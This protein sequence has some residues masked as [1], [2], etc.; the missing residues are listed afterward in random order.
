MRVRMDTPE[1][2]AGFDELR[3]DLETAIG[4]GLFP[5]VD[6]DYLMAAFV[7]VAFEIAERMLR[8]HDTDPAS[9]AEFAT[10]L[11]LGGVRNLPHRTPEVTNG[12][13]AAAASMPVAGRRSQIAGLPTSRISNGTLP[14]RAT[15]ATRSR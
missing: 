1:M 9:A 13:T 10:A 6:A 4:K 14:D 11:F 12:A 5:L 8:R 3:E 15:E 7:G 2:I